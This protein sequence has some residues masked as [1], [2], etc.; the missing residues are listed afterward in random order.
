MPWWNVTEISSL[1]RDRV[2]TMRW[3]WA[4]LTCAVIGGVLLT[5]VVWIGRHT[6]AEI[7]AIEEWIADIG[8]IGPIVFILLVLGLTSI[9]VPDTA[10]ALAAGAIYGLFWGT[11]LIFVATTITAVFDFWLSRQLLREKFV[12]MLETHP[13]LGV[14]ERAVSR[15]GLRILLLIRLT[16]VSPVVVS[17]ILGTSRLNYMPF[18][19]GCL[20]MIPG[21]FLEVYFGYLA[22]HVAKIAGE[23]HSPSRLHTALT[24]LGF[25]FSVL[26]MAYITHL[27]R[28][29]VREQEGLWEGLPR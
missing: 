25:M 2:Y 8:M 16:P 3:W 13:K 29:A 28:K 7:V 15:E 19:I 18:L 20:G 6:G 17:Y 21:L 11:V 4:V 12:R 9:F 26:V 22:Q 14:I 27:A 10:F 1:L 23:V 5:L 24:I